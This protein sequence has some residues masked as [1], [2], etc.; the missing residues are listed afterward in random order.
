MV[1]RTLFHFISLLT[2][3]TTF[4]LLHQLG[5]NNPGAQSTLV[6]PIIPHP[7]PRIDN[8]DFLLQFFIIIALIMV[9]IWRI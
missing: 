9:I 7:L 6:A 8:A 4:R 5:E 1:M 3:M 2:I